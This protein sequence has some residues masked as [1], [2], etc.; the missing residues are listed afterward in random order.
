[1]ITNG[2]PRWLNQC[3]VPPSICENFCCSAS[4]PVLEIVKLLHFCLTG[5]I[6]IVFYCIF[7]ASHM[8][9]HFLYV[10]GPFMLFFYEYDFSCH[11]LFF[12]VFN[13]SLF[14]LDTN[15]SSI[16][17]CKYLLVGDY[18]FLPVLWSLMRSL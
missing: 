16:I 8:A 5:R 6:K 17:C 1:M 18:V 10:Y 14:L 3:S 4:L 2:F 12:L 15:P 13:S 11:L 9:K 7:L